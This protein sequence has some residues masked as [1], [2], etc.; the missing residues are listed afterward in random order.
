MINKNSA[1]TRPTPFPREI[2]GGIREKLQSF[3]RDASRK[4]LVDEKLRL[5]SSTASDEVLRNITDI[6]ENYKVSLAE[7]IKIFIII[8]GSFRELFK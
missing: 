1:R 6:D 8:I 2:S 5:L 7:G 3:G 4:T